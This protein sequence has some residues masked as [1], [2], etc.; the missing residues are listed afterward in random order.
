M[1][2]QTNDSQA[3]ADRVF[4][5]FKRNEKYITPEQLREIRQRIDGVVNY[6]ARVGI[7]GKTGV[8][9][10]SLCNA[11]FGQ[12]IA[13]VSDVDAC[14]REPQ[15]INL[16]LQDGKGISLL[17]VPGVG[18]S[19]SRDEE[20]SALYQRLLP[21]LDLVLWVIKGDDRALSIDER[22]YKTILLP[23]I[24]ARTIPLVFVVNQ[25]DKV[26]P[27]KEWDWEQHRPGL[28]QAR[29]LQAKRVSISRVFDVPMV[30]ICAVSA[31]ENYGLVELVEKIVKTLPDEKKW[32]FTREA[33]QEHV[34][35]MARH[36]S[37][38]GLWETIKTAAAEII[39]ETWDVV[40]TC[41]SSIASRV[42]GWMF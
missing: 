39:S 17:D 29:N 20:Y 24:R 16:G 21:E 15:T 13:P 32:G 25:S 34:S 4:D 10:S 14:T 1:Q 31:E 9:K 28:E 3:V 35:T 2:N 40:S 37:E 12:E 8:G 26:E 6:H 41:I 42:F 19:E 38:K 11:L 33:R 23:I 7:L 36:E 22:F 27:C 5:V 30:R 18:E